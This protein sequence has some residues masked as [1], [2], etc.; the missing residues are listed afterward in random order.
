MPSFENLNISE[1][2]YTLSVL[3]YSEN[4]T[5]EL[6]YV[7]YVEEKE[8]VLEE[9]SDNLSTFTEENKGKIFL[10][11]TIVLLGIIAWVS[12]TAFGGIRKS[13]RKKHSKNYRERIKNA[14]KKIR[15]GQYLK[16]FYT[17]YFKITR[18]F[19]NGKRD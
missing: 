16:T 15:Y 6:E 12:E 11:S 3:V 14:L 7:F 5:E 10:I 1:G 4:L 18:G 13:F 8:N 17:N 9:F 2:E 19:G